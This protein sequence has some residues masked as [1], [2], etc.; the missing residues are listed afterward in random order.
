MEMTREHM[1]QNYTDAVIRS[2]WA[3]A[4]HYPSMNAF[5]VPLS[6]AFRLVNESAK[7][8]E[9]KKEGFFLISPVFDLPV[10]HRPK[11]SAL[12]VARTLAN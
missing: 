2:L 8:V 7:I 1:M 10:S 3:C 6:P 5:Q 12:D 11:W 9:R 4:E